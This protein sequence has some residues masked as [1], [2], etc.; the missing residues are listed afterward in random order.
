M[1]ISRLGTALSAKPADGARPARHRRV[2]CRVRAVVACPHPRLQPS[3]PRHASTPETPP[4]VTRPQSLPGSQ[5][6]RLISSCHVPTPNRRPWLS[7]LFFLVGRNGT[8]LTDSPAS[9]DR[10]VPSQGPACAHRVGRTRTASAAGEELSLPRAPR[11]RPPYVPHS[12]L[13]Y[14]ASAS[15]PPFPLPFFTAPTPVLYKS[16]RRPIKNHRPN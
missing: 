13:Q 8:C 14:T 4:S 2:R 10:V 6:A 5:T 11:L 16:P 9:G 15:L 1:G 12:T 3:G 7:F